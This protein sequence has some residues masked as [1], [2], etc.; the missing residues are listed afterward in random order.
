MDIE[1]KIENK[2]T[3]QLELVVFSCK[4]KRAAPLV[5]PARRVM[6]VVYCNRMISSI[7]QHQTLPGWRSLGGIRT[8]S[9][10]NVIVCAPEIGKITKPPVSV[11]FAIGLPSTVIF[12]N[13]FESTYAT[14]LKAS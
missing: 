12:Q 6:C 4:E 14:G 13:L 11:V 3:H 9:L 2:S 1:V 10:L 5:P 8:R 7:P